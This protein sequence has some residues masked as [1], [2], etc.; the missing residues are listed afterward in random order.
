MPLTVN[1]LSQRLIERARR[2][3]LLDVYGMLLTARQREAC[4]LHLEED[5][6]I[7]ELAEQLGCTRSGA[8]DLLRR[9]MAQLETYEERLGHAAE[10]SRRDA[11]EAELRARLDAQ[12]RA[13]P[14]ARLRARLAAEPRSR[15]AAE[16][17]AGPAATTGRDGVRA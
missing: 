17:R 5:W 13:R 6:S 15:G 9:A 3:R 1:S 8:H 16:L 12:L 14:E 10:L 4:R 2:Q 11:L 7:T